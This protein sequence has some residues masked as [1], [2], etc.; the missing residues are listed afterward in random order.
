M[1]FLCASLFIIVG[2]CQLAPAAAAT[3]K[4]PDGTESDVSDCNGPAGA[5][6]TLAALQGGGAV[7]C[8]TGWGGTAPLKANQLECATTGA[9]TLA[10]AGAFC[11][12]PAGAATCK[13]PDGTESDVSACNGPAGAGCTLAAL[14]GGGAVACKT[15]WGG[16]A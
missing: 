15:G 5:G 6:C 13:L 8:K 11:T 3:C 10:N 9:F 7:A 2:L 1:K 16:T 4:L 12:A 14:Q